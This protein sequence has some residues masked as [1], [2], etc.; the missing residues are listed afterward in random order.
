M[1]TTPPTF[2][3]PSR[4]TPG[5]QAM[6]EFGR[7][8]PEWALALAPTLA[9]LAVGGVFGSAGTAFKVAYAVLILALFGYLW[10]MRTRPVV[11][12]IGLLLWLSVERLVVAALS[13]RLDSSNFTWLLAYK[14]FFFPFL[15]IVGLP[16]ARRVWQASPP[17]VRFV[18][19][20]AVCFGVAIALAIVL[21]GAPLDHRITYARR[22][23]ELPLL[24][25]AA[26]LLPIRMADVRAIAT[27]IV[28]VAVPIALFGFLERSILETLIWRT[29]APAGQYYHLSVQS[30]LATYSAQEHLYK[31][32]PY[33]FFIWDFGTPFRRLVSTYL[34][35]TT[36]AMYLA[37]AGVLALA[38][39]PR[40]WLTYAVVA[41]LAVAT[42]LTLGKAGL[43]VF[44]VAGGYAVLAHLRAELREPGTVVRIAVALAAFVAVV[45][46][47]MVLF[48]LWGGALAH[49]RGLNEGLTSVSKAPLGY[50]LGYGGDFG[51]GQTGAESSLG[52]MLVQIGLPG[53]AIWVAWIVGLALACAYAARRSEVNLLSLTLGVATF[54]F[55]VTA[56][57]TESA[58]GLLGNW[59]YALLPALLLSA[60]A[61]ENG[62]AEPA[63]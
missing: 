42:A 37:L 50:G 20:A 25:L 59:P 9:P 3:P 33:N 10:A 38:I 43:L 12:I 22:F 4:S 61:L 36:L 23:A 34:E 63:K 16:R 32:L 29:I 45:A 58:G 6:L 24:Y 13:P 55:L 28:V 15:F 60:T 11:L 57:F 47:V 35:A 8:R 19:V 39:W 49:V 5:L 21:S 17:L 56:V 54:A 30:G 26:R 1:T 62:A 14:E 52:V 7:P 2:E 48:G 18:D 27:A 46:G 44:G 53:A 41:I 40:R 51:V 31:D